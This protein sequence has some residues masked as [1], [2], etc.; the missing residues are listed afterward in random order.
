MVKRIVLVVLA[1]LLPVALAVAGPQ[2]EKPSTAPAAPAAA[3]APVTEDWDAIYQAARQEGKVVIYSLS[4]RIY[5]AVKTFTEKYPGITVEAFDMGGP[6]QVEKLTREQAAAV[7]NVD[8]LNI[9]S[10]PTVVNELL[11][12][13]LLKNWVPQTLVDGKASKDVIPLAFREPALVHSVEAKVVFY[14]FETYPQA[15]VD[16]LWDLTRPEWK[17]RV[18]MKDPM[19]TEENMNLLQTI[20]QKADLMAAAYKAEFGEAITL[21]PGIRNAGYEFILRL[22]RN[23][24]VL[25]TSDGTAS[26]AVGTAGQKNPPLTFAV[27][28]SKIRDNANGQKLAIAWNLKPKIGVSKENYLLMA[29][30][31]PHPNAARLLIRWMLGDAKGEAGMTPWHVEGQWASRSDVAPIGS[32]GL[33]DLDNYTW[34]IDYAFVYKEGLAVRDF[35]LGL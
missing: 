21:S 4:S 31:A 34:F 15:P 27:A 26:K 32:V 25:V 33:A 30:K 8:V 6:D 24:L 1:I 10:G 23:D 3:P 9:A 14:N 16:S 2:G 7:Y 20:V 18:Q 17:G 35:W 11:P 28:S 12:K 13:G 29:N 5:D 22:V 19:A